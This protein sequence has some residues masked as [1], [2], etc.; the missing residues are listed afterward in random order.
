MPNPSLV[1]AAK[2]QATHCAH[3]QQVGEEFARLLSHEGEPST[4]GRAFRCPLD[5][6]IPIV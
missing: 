2:T 6:R 5:F 3:Q 4:R 1:T